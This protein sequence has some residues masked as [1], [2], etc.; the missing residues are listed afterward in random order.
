[1]AT[2]WLIPEQL[3]DWASLLHDHIDSLKVPPD[4]WNKLRDGVVKRWCSYVEP[5]ED[6]GVTRGVEVVEKEDEGEAV[7]GEGVLIRNTGVDIVV[8]VTKV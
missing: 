8:V 7:L 3:S 2:P 5:G 6:D 4:T 1:M